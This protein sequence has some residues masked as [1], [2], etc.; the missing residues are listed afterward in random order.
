MS[1][2]EAMEKAFKWIAIWIVFL[3]LCVGVAGSIFAHE[4][5]KGQISPRMLGIAFLG[6]MV[7][8]SLATFFAFRAIA[9]RVQLQKPQD[10]L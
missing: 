7:L 8:M 5:A 9:K 1:R 10:R 3:F 4:L 6:L 2:G